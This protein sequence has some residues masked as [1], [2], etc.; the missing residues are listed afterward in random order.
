MLEE[1]VYVACLDLEGVLIPE[2]WIGL[3]DRTGI[4]DL[5]A[6]T[7][8][9]PDYDELMSLRLGLLAKHGLTMRD[10][11]AVVGGLVPLEGASDFFDWLRG[12]CQVAILSDTFYELAIPLMAQL[13]RPR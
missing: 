3:A 2:I 9:I 1:R 11:E 12:Q 4:D 10:L 6:T 5:R 13:G 7:R 8:D